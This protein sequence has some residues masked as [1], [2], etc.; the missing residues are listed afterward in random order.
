MSLDLKLTEASFSTN[1]TDLLCL[2][3][4]QVP[5]SLNNM[6]IFVPAMTTYQV[7]DSV[8]SIETPLL[9]NDMCRN[10]LITPHG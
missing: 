3:I 2:G 9:E 4:A 5:R 6:M 8:L 1:S 10:A 7:I